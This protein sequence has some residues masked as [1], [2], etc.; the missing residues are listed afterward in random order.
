MRI[1]KIFHTMN[2]INNSE[3]FDEIHY[4]KYYE[5]MTSLF[6]KSSFLSSKFFKKKWHAIINAEKKLIHNFYNKNSNNKS[7]LKIIKTW[8]EKTHYHTIFS[9]SISEILF[10]W[11]SHLDDTADLIFPKWKWQ[12]QSHWPDLEDALNE[13]QIHMIH[14]DTTITGLS[15]HKM[16]GI[17]WNRLLQYQNQEKPHFSQDWLDDFKKQ[18]EIKQI[19]LL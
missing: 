3:N 19:C 15:L 14:K 4:T 12:Q 16:T 2:F 7:S 9:S 5:E 10:N 6:S 18:Y 11:Y 13:W 17:I 8:F 1:N